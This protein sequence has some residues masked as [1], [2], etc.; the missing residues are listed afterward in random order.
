MSNM[1]NRGGELPNGQRVIGLDYLR[2]SLAIL[3]FLF[4]SH[5]HVLQCDYGVFNGFIDMGAI[6]MTGFFLLSGYTLNLT[7]KKMDGDDDIKRFYIKRLISIVPLYFAW[8]LL[9]VIINVILEGKPAVLEEMIL[10]PIEALG[11]QSVFA[12]LF[13]FS[14]N[15]GSWFIS[16]ILICYFIYPLIQI[17]TK[18]LSDKTRIN[19][20]IILGGILLYSPFVERYFDLQSIYSNPF[21]RLL[22]FIIG[23]LVSQMNVQPQT[24]NRIISILRKPLSCVVTII[25]LVGGVSVA[26]YIGIPHIYMLY[27]W[28]AL[29]CFISLLIS[30]GYI[31]FRSNRFV[32]Y[33][34][35]IS[36]SIFLSQLLIVW[37][38]V[39]YILELVG[40]ES[41]TAKIL[42]SAT[43]CFGIANFF[44]YC[45]EKPS[46]KYF[47]S[48]FVN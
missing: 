11:I 9:N 20:I 29:P 26:Y 36:F 5:I 7:Y 16:C 27:S 17:L 19:I 18:S 44:H 28:I 42:L 43:I 13:S 40:C 45:I 12:S 47:K 35:N 23:I 34:S 6:A 38:G 24:N 15:G 3:I 22:E 46:A 10:F 33:M 37:S 21:F 1:A 25:C 39:K 41:N 14:H 30:L 8:A 31:K 48:K 4:H 2:I 32:L